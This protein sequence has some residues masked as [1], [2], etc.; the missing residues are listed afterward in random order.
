MKIFK[1]DL[2]VHTVLSPCAAIEMIP[3]LIVQ[4]ALSQGIN[5]IAITDH[6]ATANITAV[7]KAAVGTELTVLPGMEVQTK[8]EVHVLCIFDT[9][10]QTEAWQSI[11]DRSLPNIE[12]RPDFFGEQYVVDETGDFIRHE[13]RL[14]L[15]ST[16]L[17][18]EEV[19]KKVKELGGLFIPAHVNRKAFGLLA[20]LG[21][22]PENVRVEA[23]EISRHITPQKANE[24]YPQ[25]NGYPLIQNGDVHY[26]DE[27]LGS[28]HYLLEKPETCELLY[29]ILQQNGRSLTIV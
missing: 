4:E 29:A 2:H 23:L 25:I 10:E 15:N 6:N 24:T 14:L 21:L 9:L 8:E 1:A 16:D 13:E 5:L 20:N 22:I 7:Q 28:S 11:V 12:N 3:P 26:I 27:F 17:T 19:A 18:F